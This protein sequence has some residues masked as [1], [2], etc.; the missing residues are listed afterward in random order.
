MTQKAVLDFLLSPY[1]FFPALLLVR[2][3]V[4][5]TLEFLRP[6]RNVPFRAV[7]KNDLV[8]LL[9][10]AYLIFPLAGALNYHVHGY[11]PYLARFTYLPLTIRIGMYFVLADFGHYW[12][13]RFV[14]TRY[15][16][17]VHKWHHSPTYM[18]WLGGVRATVPQQF[19]VNI[20]Y[21]LAYPLLQVSPWWLAVVILIVN[22]VQNDWMHMN[23]TWRS[24]WLEW[25]FVTPRYHHI[26]HSDDPR[27]FLA[28]LGNLFTAWD[29]LFGTY[30]D[31]DTVHEEISFGI[32]TKE[33]PLRLILGV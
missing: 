18:Y 23:V 19:L 24:D 27:H 29:R 5:G 30:V 6:A 26:H 4:F 7:V 14:H 25:I 9:A 31:P 22:A 13:H 1:A 15:L 33:N 32:D 2:T 10:Y 3:V 20:P 28:N 11:H 17:R 12:V 8:A 16:W 21:I